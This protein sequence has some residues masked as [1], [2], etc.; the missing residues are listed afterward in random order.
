VGV[1]NSDLRLKPGMTANVSIIVARKDGIIKVPNSALRFKP[2]QASVAVPAGAGGRQPVAGGGD[3]VPGKTVWKMGESGDPEPVTLQSG[4]SDG[5]FTEVVS[6]SLSEGDQIVVGLDTS[7]T[8]ARSDLPPGFGGSSH[9]R[10][11][12]RDRGL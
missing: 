2:P 11:R 9:S 7:R 5:S 3:F 12:G 6:G 1:E 10:P 4:I 8:A